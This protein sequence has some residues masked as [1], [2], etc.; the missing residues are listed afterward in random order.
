M[1]IAICDDNEKKCLILREIIEKWMKDNHKKYDIN[2]FFNGKNLLYEM[3]EGQCFDLVI[4][5]IEMPQMNGMEVAC[6]LKKY[7]SEILIIFVSCY[8]KYVYDSFKVQPFR[9]VPWNYLYQ[10]LPTA[11]EDAVQWVEKCE[12]KYLYIENNNSIRKVS[13]RNIL[14]I[15]YSEKYCYIYCV[16]G[17]QFRV[18]KY[19]KD[20]YKELPMD[21]FAWVNRGCICNLLHVLKIE[22]NEL[23][24]IGSI[25]HPISYDRIV[26]IKN[27]LRKY[28]I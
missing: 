25:K 19:L 14:Y 17:E 20:I 2:V 3:E 28:W 23:L 6:D 24:M 22:K 27:Q 12:G 10:M 5:D 15:W 4:L 1:K 18:R 9:F 7:Q 11:L 21:D 8:E 13:I 26:D 16:N